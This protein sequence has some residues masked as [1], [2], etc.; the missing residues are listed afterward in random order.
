MSDQRIGNALWEMNQRWLPSLVQQMK[1]IRGSMET[2]AQCYLWLHEKD[3]AFTRLVYSQDDGGLVV[4]HGMTRLLVQVHHAEREIRISLKVIGLVGWENACL[5][6]Y[7]LPDS[8][9]ALLKFLS[10]VS[11]VRYMNKE[12]QLVHYF[13]SDK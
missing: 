3:N 12:K 13:D 8:M 9:Q 1:D 2:I 11:T 7:E 6:D 10:S 4:M 5:D